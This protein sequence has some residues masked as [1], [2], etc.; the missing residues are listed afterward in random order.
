MRDFPVPTLGFEQMLPQSGSGT[1][2]FG[3]AGQPAIHALRSTHELTRTPRESAAIHATWA[4]NLDEVREAQRLRYS[5]FADEMGAQLTSPLPG[6][7]IDAFDDFCEHLIV[8]AVDTNQVVGTYRVLM[9][10]QA[11]RMGS[12]YTETEF[13]LS[14]CR[15]TRASTVELGRSCV[16]QSHRTG[17]AIFALWSEL[18]S[19]MAKHDMETMIGC[20]SIPMRC[21]GQAFALGPS[22]AAS[23]FRKLGS[24]VA[25]PGHRAKPLC[26]LPI[27]EL[28]DSLDVE[29]PAL[30]KAYLR[31][32]AGILGEPA[33]DPDF[34]TADLPMCM[35]LGDLP[36]RYRKHFTRKA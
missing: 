35:R 21:A 6:H 4:V 18:A 9:P 15:L 33:W 25:E 27:T 19:F 7:D 5:V 24:C 17:P 2:F 20:A 16:H 23:V 28:D 3:R 11:K 1:G 13:D 30:I 14:D 22:M 36:S 34:N 10:D 12:W 8:R 31:L 32:G 29:P 26:P